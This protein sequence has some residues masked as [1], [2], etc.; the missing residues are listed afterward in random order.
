MPLEIA[1]FAYAAFANFALAKPRHRREMPQP[2]FMTP[3]RNFLLGWLLLA[4]SGIAAGIGIVQPQ[5]AVTWV[6]IICIA[7][8][9]FVLLLSRWPRSALRLWMP[10]GLVAIILLLMALIDG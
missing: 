8:L 4:M 3:P 7:G 1:C 2:A 9:A 6:G 5:A 10:A